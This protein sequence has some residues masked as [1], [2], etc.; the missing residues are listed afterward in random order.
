MHKLTILITREEN[1]KL[2]ELLKELQPESQTL[3]K[4]NMILV[5]PDYSLT[6]ERILREHKIPYSGYEEVPLDNPDGFTAIG[7][8]KQANFIYTPD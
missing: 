1:S 6:I 5:Q 7:G 2:V 8:K 3:I 4:D